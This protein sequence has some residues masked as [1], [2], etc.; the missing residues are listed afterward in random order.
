MAGSPLRKVITLM[1]DQV[2]KSMQ[3][4]M[5]IFGIGGISQGVAGDVVRRIADPNLSEEEF[6]TLQADVASRGY[7]LSLAN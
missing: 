7:E 2:F 4:V 1:N 6:R 3:K 5:S